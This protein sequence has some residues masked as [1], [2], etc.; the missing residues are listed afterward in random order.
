MTLDG[1]IALLK[2]QRERGIYITS[3]TSLRSV[4]KLRREVDAILVGVQTI[5][6]DD[7]QLTVRYQ[8]LKKHCSPPKVIIIDP[9]LRTPLNATL[10]KHHPKNNILILGHPDKVADK[11]HPLHEKCMV[12]TAPFLNKKLEWKK[13]LSKLYHQGIGHILLEGGAQVFSSALEDGI[14]DKISLYVAPIIGGIT[15][16][17]SF[18][19]ELNLSHLSVKKSGPD[20]HILG[21][22]NNPLV[23]PGTNES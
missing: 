2:S 12:K 23:W 6:M 1:K 8:M 20:L 4:H 17:T 5:V 13:C 14:V 22:S 3:E 9:N 11:N 10:F 15:P 19:K 21:Y 18:S 7:P 16:V